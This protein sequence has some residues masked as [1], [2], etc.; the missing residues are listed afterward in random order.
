MP[1]RGGKFTK[2][3]LLTLS[4]GHTLYHRR[5]QMESLDPLDLRA[6][7]PQSKSSNPWRAI[8]QKKYRLN[9]LTRTYCC[10][11]VFE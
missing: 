5:I 7:R 6:Y 4:A 8:R 2:G 3:H 11:I 10:P 1:N 9:Q